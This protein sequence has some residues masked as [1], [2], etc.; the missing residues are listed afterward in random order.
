MFS[1][2]LSFLSL[3]HL[4]ITLTVSND[5]SQHTECQKEYSEKNAVR[6][7]KEEIKH[8]EEKQAERASAFRV[9]K[10]L[11]SHEANIAAAQSSARA[12][13]LQVITSQMNLFYDHLNQLNVTVDPNSKAGQHHLQIQSFVTK[14]FM[15]AKELR[16]K[17]VASLL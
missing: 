6:L 3:S 4:S 11:M 15:D 9:S 17:L 14:E 13:A 16:D 12:S 1:S 5:T 7:H 8:S 10:D 2:V